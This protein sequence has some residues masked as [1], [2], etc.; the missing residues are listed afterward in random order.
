MAHDGEQGLQLANTVQFDLI[1]TDFNMPRMNGGDFI[2]N[3]KNTDSLS[4]N[5]RIFLISG[6]LDSPKNGP[7]TIQDVLFLN[8]PIRMDNL[9]DHTRKALEASP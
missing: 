6:H 5:T 1:I 7:D 8:K 9:I 4:K 2:K 3:L